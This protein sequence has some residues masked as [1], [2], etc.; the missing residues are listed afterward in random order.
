MDTIQVLLLSVALFG[1]GALASLLLSGSHRAARVTAGLMGT[2]ASLTGLISAILAAI[3]TPA[4]LK[5]FVPLPFGQFTLQMDGL[6]ALMVGMICLLSLAVSFYSISYF[7]HY[8]ERNAG[9]LGFFINLFIAMML[10]VVT[11]DNAFYFL[12][13]WEMMTLASYFLVIFEGEKKE[14]V[15]AGYLYMLVAH[16]GTAL[17]MLAFFVFY[18]TAG[19]FDFEAFRLSQLSPVVRNLI[20]V[21]AF[22]GFGAKAGMVPLHIWLPRA[23]PAAPSPVSALL[24]GVML[25][26]ALYGILRICV[27]ILGTSVL[28][29]GMLVLGFGVLSAVIGVFYAL[30]EKDIKRILAYSSVENVGIILMG[31]GVGMVGSATR[32]P[33]V[34]LIGFLAALYHA[35]NHSLF[36]GLLFLG[37]GSIDYSIHTRNLNEMGGLGKLMP[38]TSLM[39]LAG[40]LSI[41]AMPPF[42]GF[43]SEWFTYQAFFTASNGQDFIVRVCLPL[44]AAVLALV[45]TLSAMVAIKMYSSAFSGPA[46]SEKAG[47]ASEVPDPM[48]SGM[49]FLAIG[50]VLLGLCAPLVAPYLANVVSSTFNIH[51]MIV[52]NGSWVYPVATAQG[53]LSAPLI[54]ILLLGLL[55]VPVVLIAIY[56][57]RKAGTKMVNDPWACGYG[58]S[59]EMSVTASNFDQPI[60]T[61]FNVIYQLRPIIQKPLD[62]IGAW[63]KRVRD[64]ITRAEPVLENIIKQPTTRSVEYVG[65]HIQALQMGDVRM[66]CLYIIVTLI[67]LLIAVFK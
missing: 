38:W 31:I 20:F 17:I 40:G 33:T 11:I 26:T 13:F 10:L 48:L 43:V 19:T 52:A 2:I 50:C 64:A 67:V 51:P 49:A 24:S 21:L 22:F 61:T 58:Y 14:S 28:W 23:H 15:Q 57:D 42:N 18:I 56:G 47:K 37:A 29:W 65:R 35:L 45:G 63:S 27:D 1:V 7:K 36:K 25:K 4:P 3:H 39:F 16:T 41:A 8:P 44:C 9:T 54:A 5:L 30:A 60:T 12:I 34:E 55:T 53:V 6:S 62:A 59:S 32:Q 46:R 66:Y